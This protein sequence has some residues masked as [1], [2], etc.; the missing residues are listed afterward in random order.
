MPTQV[1]RGLWAVFVSVGPGVS[2]DWFQSGQ[3]YGKVRWFNAHLLR[4]RPT[5]RMV[6]IERVYHVGTPAGDLEVDV[7]W[8]NIGSEVATF[9]VWF[10]E[11]VS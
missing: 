8:K 7:V 2:E 10:A 4:G 6:E 1:N 9:A 3:T 5:T 11:T